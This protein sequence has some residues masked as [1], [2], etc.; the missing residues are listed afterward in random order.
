MHSCPTCDQA[1]YC[2][3]DIDDCEVSTEIDCIH[4]S[5]EAESDDATGEAALS[6]LL[7]DANKSNVKIIIKKLPK[8]KL[9][10][11]K[12]SGLYD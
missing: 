8:Q 6:A 9:A 1:C 12:K 10:L 11:F 4:C 2:C 3:G 7:D 5:E